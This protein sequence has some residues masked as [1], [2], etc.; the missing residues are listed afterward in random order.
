MNIAFL[1]IAEPYQCYHGLAVAF[2]L[3]R[4]PGARVTIYYNDPESVYHLERIRRAYGEAPFD[5]IRMKRNLFAR[6]VERIRIFGFAKGSIYR[7]NEP[8]LLAYDAIFTVEDTAFRLFEGRRA[9]ER[10]KKIYL[11]HGAG[12]GTVGFSSRLRMFD[13][14]LVAGPKSAQRML[15]LGHIRAD[16]YHEVGLV[17]LETA[18]LLSHASGPLFET[19]RPT[20]LYNA[21]KTRGLESWSTFIEPMLADFAAHDA[22][23][24]IVA[25]HVKL[26]RRRSARTKAYW[27]SRSTGNVL[28]DVGS[29][30]SVDM[31]YTRAADIYV[32]DISSQVYEFLAEP[33]P[34]VFLNP[35]NIDWVDNPDF[36][37]WHLGDVISRPQDLM[38][39]IEAAP[40][41]HHLYRER[42][43]A[44]A[45]ASLGDRSPGAAARAAQ[46]IV[47]FLRR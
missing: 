14:V 34:C 35:H 20:V 44:R 2:E 15:E 26:F 17:K 40:A 43:E 27:Q 1:F 9:T 21:H 41:R 42:Q 12:D 29:D 11:P 10:P 6:V 16:Q 45:A 7:S 31:S 39:A 5:Y 19:A 32:G 22:Y 46:A 38:P 36:A 23:N 24:L 28:V 33:R 18:D 37:H 13:Y 3:R 8:D 47:A 25:P 30:G 4:V